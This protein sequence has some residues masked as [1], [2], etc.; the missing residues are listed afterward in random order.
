MIDWKITLF[1]ENVTRSDKS[2]ALIGLKQEVNGRIHQAHC[3]KESAGIG[4]VIMIC[5]L[6]S[7]ASGSKKLIISRFL[8][9]RITLG[10]EALTDLHLSQNLLESL[11]DSLGSLTR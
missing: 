7:R 10:L 3:D 5:H 11:P 2:T 8:T 1:G 6:L 9:S 4:I